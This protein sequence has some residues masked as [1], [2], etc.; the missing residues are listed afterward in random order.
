MDHD[1]MVFNTY[2]KMNPNIQELDLFNRVRLNMVTLG[3]QEESRVMCEGANSVD[4]IVKG[5]FDWS[6]DDVEQAKIHSRRNRPH[7]PRFDNE[8]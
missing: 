4:D 6:D 2:M 3:Y 7:D 5:A 8:P 1:K